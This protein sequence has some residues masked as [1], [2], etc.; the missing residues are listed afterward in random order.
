MNESNRRIHF[1]SDSRFLRFVEESVLF[2][3]NSSIVVRRMSNN[4]L[5]AHIFKLV[6]RM[7]ASYLMLL[8]NTQTKRALVL[9]LEPHASPMRG[10]TEPIAFGPHDEITKEEFR[11]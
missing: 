3:F 11:L 1:N 6:C 2:V 9:V 10:E 4:L 7:V 8:H 5:V